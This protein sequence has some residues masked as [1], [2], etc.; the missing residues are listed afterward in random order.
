M[1]P[2][3]ALILLVA[4]ALFIVAAKGTQDNVIAAIKGKP[5]GNSTLGGSGVGQHPGWVY[6]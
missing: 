2:F 6:A 4:I 3:A 5:Y 1:N